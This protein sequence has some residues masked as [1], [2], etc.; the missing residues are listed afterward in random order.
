[1]FVLWF[2]I[3]RLVQKHYRPRPTPHTSDPAEF[4]I[5]FEQVRFPAADGGS[6]HGWWIPGRSDAPVLILVHGWQN[7]A[8]RLMRFI[9]ELHPLGY[10]LLAFDARSHGDSTFTIRTTVW[11]YTEDT[12]AAIRFV[13]EQTGSP[14]GLLGFSIGGGAAINAAAH[15]EGI[16]SVLTVGAVAHPLEVM[17]MAFDL[18]GVPYF[19]LVWMFF[20]YLELRYSIRFDRIAPV[21]HIG[22]VQAPVFLIHGEDDRIVLPDQS[23]QLL[24][25]GD[26]DSTRIWIASG[27]GHGEWDEMPLFWERVKAFLEETVP[28]A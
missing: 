1:L 21:Q 16:R 28:V 9:R 17:R 13:R 27:L 14:I 22:K 24:T 23:R 6:L 2:T 25:A 26:P 5:P 3:D 10:S 18:K 4:G 8:G 7:N 11:S 20:R 12:L 19:P 15:S